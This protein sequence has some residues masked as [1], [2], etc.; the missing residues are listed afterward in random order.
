[1]LLA[2]SAAAT[3]GAWGPATAPVA[4]LGVVTIAAV[5]VALLFT[6]LPHAVAPTRAA[7]AVGAFASV[8]V[9]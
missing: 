8:W 6:Y 4:F 9:G 7:A 2:A 3:A 1:M 5:A